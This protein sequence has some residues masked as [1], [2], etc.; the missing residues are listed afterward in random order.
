MF[1]HLVDLIYIDELRPV[2]SC[3]PVFRIF[4]GDRPPAFWF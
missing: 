2:D 1:F 4:K 3:T